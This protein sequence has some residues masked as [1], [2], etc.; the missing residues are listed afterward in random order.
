[1]S[2]SVVLTR[3][4]PELNMTVLHQIIFNKQFSSSHQ[5]HAEFHILNALKPVSD[6]NSDKRV[7]S[8][9]MLS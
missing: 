9:R 1:M 8:V 4:N 7:F 5:L 2:A 3:L 6:K